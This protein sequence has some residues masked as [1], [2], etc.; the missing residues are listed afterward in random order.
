MREGV[1]RLRGVD[2]PRMDRDGYFGMSGYVRR[3]GA[4]DNERKF[5]KYLDLLGFI[6]VHLAIGIT[7]VLLL[8]CLL[9]VLLFVTSLF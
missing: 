5:T 3:V 1:A 9:L 6:S 4:I 8:Y 2:L 7:G